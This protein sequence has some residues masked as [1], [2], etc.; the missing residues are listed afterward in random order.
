MGRL[1]FIILIIVAVIL[2]WKAFGPSSWK[3]NQP[4]HEAPRQVKG[5]DDDE[6]FLWNLEKEAFK[7]RRE[8]ERRREQEKR[9]KPDEDT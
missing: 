2:L 6:E 5:P 3:R 1:L 9:D 4:Q 8:E 7:R